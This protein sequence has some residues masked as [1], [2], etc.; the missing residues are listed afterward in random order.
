MDPIFISALPT[1]TLTTQN[2]KEQ[3]WV[4]LRSF[5]L[6]YKLIENSKIYI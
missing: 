3:I 1:P 4:I 2:A 5:A 6:H